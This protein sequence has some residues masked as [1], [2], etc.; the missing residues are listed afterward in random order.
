MTRSYFLSR[1]HTITA[2]RPYEGPFTDLGAFA[3]AS[4]QSPFV[5]DHESG[6]TL[7]RGDLVEVVDPDKGDN[8]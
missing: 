7:M 6:M 8:V 3:V 4:W 2:V 1:A 5:P